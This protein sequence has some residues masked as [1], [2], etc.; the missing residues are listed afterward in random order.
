MIG[1]EPANPIIRHTV[2]ELGGQHT[3]ILS[4]GLTIRQYFVAQ[5]MQGMLASESEE[6][7]FYKVGQVAAKACEVVDACL[8]EELRTRE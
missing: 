3:E 5:A 2:D 7:G 6:S 1:D 8:A 4:H